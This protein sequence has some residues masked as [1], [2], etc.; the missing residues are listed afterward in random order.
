MQ[1]FALVLLLASTTTTADPGPGWL[2]LGYVWAAESDGVKVLNVQ[3]VTPGGPA[4]KAGVKPGDIITTI[5]ERRVD[6]GD[7]LDLL[8][9]LGDR[10]PGERLTLGIVREGKRIEIRLRLGTMPETSRQAWKQN[11]EVARR[12]RLATAQ[13]Q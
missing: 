9:F 6:F 8:L 11:L 12:Q 4:E 10:K 2:G 5:N 3:R 13:R 7:E 1:F